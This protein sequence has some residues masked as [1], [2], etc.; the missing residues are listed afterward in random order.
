MLFEVVFCGLK[1]KRLF[2]GV[3][4]EAWWVDDRR[5]ESAVLYIQVNSVWRQDKP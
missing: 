1:E 2:V 4:R 3:E 5:D